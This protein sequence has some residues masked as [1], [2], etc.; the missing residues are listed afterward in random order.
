M[1]FPKIVKE[2][3]SVKP[4][5]QGTLKM[6]INAPV[7]HVDFFW[8]HPNSSLVHAIIFWNTAITVDSAANVINKKNKIPQI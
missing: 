7:I 5:T 3:Q 1:F 2:D 4:N 6:I 8:D